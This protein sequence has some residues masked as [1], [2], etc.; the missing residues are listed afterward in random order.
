MDTFNP[1]PLPLLYKAY[2]GVSSRKSWIDKNS[3][4]KQA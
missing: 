4:V 2:F 1:Q 3:I